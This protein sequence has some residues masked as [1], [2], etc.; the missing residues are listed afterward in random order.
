MRP[1]IPR[2]F[3][4]SHV[5]TPMEGAQLKGRW[6]PPPTGDGR[7]RSGGASGRAPPSRLVRGRQCQGR[8]VV[9]GANPPRKGAGM[10][11][12]GDG[13]PLLVHKSPP[14]TGLEKPRRPRNTRPIA[15]PGPQPRSAGSRT[16]EPTSRAGP[17][18]GMRRQTGDQYKRRRRSSKTSNTPRASK[19]K[20]TAANQRP[21]PRV[22]GHGTSRSWARITTRQT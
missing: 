1:T 6:V 12:E 3:Q 18:L 14:G 5:A 9:A 8:P 4:E 21:Q 10:G 11:V 2:F 19:I 17:V 13:R 20:P 22:G 16:W 15:W 7:G